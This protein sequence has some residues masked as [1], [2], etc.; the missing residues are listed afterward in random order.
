MKELI[1]MGGIGWKALF[2]ISVLV[3]L[4]GLSPLFNPNVH[5][6][7]G[8]F[9][10]MAVGAVLALFSVFHGKIFSL[11]RVSKAARIVF[12][13]IIA[14]AIVFIIISAVVSAL[15]IKAANDK[16]ENLS[17]I[18][19][20]GCRVNG[21]NPSAM[22]MQRISAACRYLEEYPEAVVIASGGKG[23][24]ELI[25]EAECIR[26]QL[27]KRGIS[28]ERIILEEKSTSTRENMI[29]SKALLE[30]KGITGEIAIVTNEYHLLRAKTIAKK[31]GLD[32]KCCA[33]RT[34]PI[35][36]P[37]YWVREI[38]GNVYEFLF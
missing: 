22:L 5:L 21:E 20:L 28:P 13:V 27:E 15:M 38:F 1:N 2:V 23:G 10:I 19:V 11:I 17:A 26:R 8:N 34:V 9:V 3:F 6:N 16:P 30:E 4:F 32:V 7:F 24:D 35:Y 33:A 18:I 37:P 25:S 14:A 12:C 29:F 36:L 31:Q